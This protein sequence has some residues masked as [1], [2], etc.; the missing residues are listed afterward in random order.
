MR[1]LL[2]YPNSPHELIGYGD[3]GAIAEPLALEYLATATAELGHQVRILDLR[4]HRDEL[5]GCLEAY[6]PDIVGITGYSM[7]VLRMLNIAAAVR[8]KLAGCTVVIGGHHATL[9]PED[10]FAEVVDFV[11]SGEG[12]RPFTKLITRLQI[13][14]LADEL[15]AGLWSRSEPRGNFRLE[16]K[17]EL[18]D[19]DSL[20][21]PNR[22][23]CSEDRQFYFIDW[24]RP[25]ALLRT[26]VGCP[27][28][29]TF[30]S[31]W[32]IT[33]GAYHI[34]VVDRIVEELRQIKEECVFLVDDEPFVNH[35][36][37]DA[38]ESAIRSA[39]IKKRYFAYCRIDTLI[40]QEQ[41]IRAWRNIGLERLFIGIEAVSEQGLKD[42]NKHLALSQVEVGLKLARKIG[43]SI[44]AGF[45]VS[46]DYTRDD[47]TRLKRFIEHH[48]IEYPSFTILTPIP[49]TPALLSFDQVTDRQSNGRP[50]WDS[51]DLQHLVVKPSLPADEFMREYRGLY[52]TFGKSYLPFH[53]NIKQLNEAIASASGSRW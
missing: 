43:I 14:N 24:M 53:D 11:I 10:F 34:R 9:M 32:R 2:V 8:T 4:L 7:H 49:G 47:F 5:E 37:M 3:M 29:C 17:Q 35:H 38:L 19:L 45:V 42:Y 21:H 26:S 41:T 44:F 6:C 15:I 48:R 18:I 23:V 51:F 16:A 31:L 22:E 28:R 39:T 30:C 46:T 13:G 27:Y 40:R 52:K 12:V 1:V 36:R 33:D 20:P 50:N 25:I